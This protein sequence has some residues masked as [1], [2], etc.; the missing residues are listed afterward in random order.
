[1]DNERKV[2][3]S[4]AEVR[5]RIAELGA[6][7]SK[8]YADVT[9]QEPLLALCTLRGA[10]FFYADLVRALEIPCEI[11]FLKVHSYDGDRPAGAPV[12]D[13]G[14]EIEVKGRDVLIVEDIVDTGATL[15]AILDLFEQKGAKSIRICTLLNKNERR[16][17]HLKPRIA[18]EYIGFDVPDYFVVG[19][20]LD[21]NDRYRLLKDICDLGQGE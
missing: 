17:P 11:D 13:L 20:G 15:E 14:E 10:V 6:Q 5:A 12:F 7:I 8:D 9:E 4:D 18:P 19:W 2:L 16:L 3:Y 1:M 21:Y